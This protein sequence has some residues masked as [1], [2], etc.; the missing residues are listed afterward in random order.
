MCVCAPN[1]FYLGK[2]Q[3]RRCGHE[4]A[5]GVFKSHALARVR[6]R[7]AKG[8]VLHADGAPTWNDLHAR[9]ETKRIDHQQAYS[10]D[11]TRQGHTEAFKG[12]AS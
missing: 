12:L 7:V 5:P 2:I 1:S 4:P 10:L 3:S 11:G 6:H 8:T 9:Y